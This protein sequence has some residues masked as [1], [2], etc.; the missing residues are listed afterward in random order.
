MARGTTHQLANAAHFV[1]IRT[2]NDTLSAIK[3]MRD[4]DRLSARIDG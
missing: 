1:F 3:R 2:Y 4:P